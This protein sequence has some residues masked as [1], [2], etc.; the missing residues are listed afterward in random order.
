[1]A[2]TAIES[3]ASTNKG[4]KLIYQVRGSLLIVEYAGRG[5]YLVRKLFKCNSQELNF[6]STNL[7]PIPPSL[8]LC[9]PVD[10][11]EIKY[12]N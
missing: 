6:I 11:S 4:A 9:E 3:E 8:K 1:M 10:S 7:Y 2:R 5:N 12:L